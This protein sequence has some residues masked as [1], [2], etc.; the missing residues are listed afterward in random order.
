[1]KKNISGYLDRLE[2]D[3]NIIKPLKPINSKPNSKL[4]KYEIEDNFLNF[5]FRFIYKYQ[6]LIESENFNGLRQIILRDFSLHKGKFLEKMYH[7]LFRLSGKWTKIGRY[8]E[9]GNKNEIDLVAIDEINKKIVIVEI[10][11]N[12]ERLNK[13]KLILKSQKLINQF[14]DYNID[15]KILSLKDIHLN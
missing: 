9:R 1:M 14:S 2:K 15:F 12:Q 11:L 3:Y 5:W 7:E 13:N 8:W 10:K 4:Q 6:S